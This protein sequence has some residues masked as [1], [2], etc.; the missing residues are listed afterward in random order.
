MQHSISSIVNTE[1]RNLSIAKQFL[2]AFKV[3]PPAHIPYRVIVREDRICPKSSL[4]V[5]TGV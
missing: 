1:R 5:S 4:D 3:S 2:D